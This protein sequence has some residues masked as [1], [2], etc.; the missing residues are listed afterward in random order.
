[1]HQILDTETIGDI[2][3]EGRR[4]AAVFERVGIG[5][6]CAG[7]RTVA[8]D[9]RSAGVE[10]AGV[11]RALAAIGEAEGDA[12]NNVLFPRAIALDAARP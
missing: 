1:M 6:C 5:F 12:V 3:A 11:E 8:A 4:A 10:L 7:R 2:V 9:G